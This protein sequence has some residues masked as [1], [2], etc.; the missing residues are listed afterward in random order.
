MLNSRVIKKIVILLD[1]KEKSFFKISQIYLSAM[2]ICLAIYLIYLAVVQ[3]K[4][5]QANNPLLVVVVLR[6]L[7]SNSH[8]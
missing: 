1:L 7:I 4:M 3:R 6:I 5:L 8:A 2:M